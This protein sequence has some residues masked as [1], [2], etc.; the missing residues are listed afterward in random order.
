MKMI[1]GSRA[2][3]LVIRFG[4]AAAEFTGTPAKCFAAYMVFRNSVVERF[5]PG[6]GVEVDAPPEMGEAVMLLDESRRKG[7][8]LWKELFELRLLQDPSPRNVIE[9]LRGQRDAADQRCPAVDEGKVG[10]TLFMKTGERF[11]LEVDDGNTVYRFFSTP[12]KA[13]I[14]YM[15]LSNSAVHGWVPKRGLKLSTAEEAL[16]AVR[17]LNKLRKPLTWRRLYEWQALSA[18][19]PDRMIRAVAL[20]RLIE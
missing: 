5:V 7:V 12:S 19:S 17:I 20:E 4:N 16:E 13:Y 15:L 9:R 14:S 1:V 6:A 18:P 10:R 2:A 8:V 3:R 11:S